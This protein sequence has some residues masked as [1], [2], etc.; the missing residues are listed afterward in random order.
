[1]V[2]GLEALQQPGARI[3]GVGLGIDL[4]DGLNRDAA[5]FL[6]AFV[7]AHAVRHNGQPALQRE[8]RIAGRFPVGI[9]V[10]II[11]SLAA[12][13]AQARQLNTGPNFHSTP[14]LLTA[15]PSGIWI[16]PDKARLDSEGWAGHVAGL[17]EVKAQADPVASI[18]ISPPLS[19]N[20]SGG[21]TANELRILQSR[22][23]RIQQ[24]KANGD[25]SGSER[26]AGARTDRQGG[27]SVRDGAVRRG[28]RPDQ[29]QAGSCAL[30]I[31]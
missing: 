29:A 18:G 6:A 10:L 5:G 16:I 25:G 23:D 30:I 31:W 19:Y 26:A 12:H 17:V 13:I 11:F 22:R 2:R 9:A 3:A 28:R 14:F 15:Y 1:M 24:M 8:L 21:P 4:F 20:A 27:W 7:S